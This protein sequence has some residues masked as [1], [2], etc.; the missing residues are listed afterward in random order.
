MGFYTRSIEGY[1]NKFKYK[2]IVVH[3]CVVQ[4]STTI[5]MALVE[6]KWICF[7]CVE[8]IFLNYPQDVE[9]YFRQSYTPCG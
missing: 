6:V 5:H 1:R 2:S 4:T 3:K 7:P 8:A 9:E